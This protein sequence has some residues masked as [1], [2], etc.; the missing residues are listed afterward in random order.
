MSAVRRRSK[1]LVLLV[2]VVG[3][4]LVLSACAFL[5]EGSLSVSQSADI[6]AAH[7]H[8]VLCT[9][10]EEGHCTP[11]EINE[12]PEGSETVQYLIGIAV[13]KGAPAPAAFT[14]QPI[15]PGTHPINFTRDDQ[16]ASEIT[17][18]NAKLAEAELPPE[19]GEIKPWPPAGLEGVGYLSDPVEEEEGALG[20]WAVDAEFGLP[21][22]S[23]GSPFTGPF[24]A[25][26]TEGARQV[27]S[28]H[29]AGSPVHCWRFEGTFEEGEAFCGPT[30]EEAQVGTSDLKIAAPPTA[31]V[32]VGGKATPVF[33]LNLGSTASSLPSFNVTAT[34]T[35]P[36]ASVTVSAPNFAPPAVDPGTH[37]SGGSETVTVAVPKTAKPGVY[38]VTITAKTAQGGTATQVAKIEVTKPKLKLGKVKL[39]KSNGTVKLSIGVPGAG[40]LTVSGKKIVK[41]KRTAKGPKTIKVTIK[42]KGKAKKALGSTGK[43]KV[44]AKI[45]FKPSNGASV[46]KTKSITLKKKLG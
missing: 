27:S 26:I 32:F 15:S 29:P 11:N 34:S 46:T 45:V 1:Y 17:A 6:G 7:V 10:P 16:V 21:V 22:P 12:P 14:A 18:S 44:K 38:E 43:A 3:L 25:A 30:V 4:A 36:G 8:F 13:P 23:D 35:L 9:E 31:P 20:E 39:I 2:A 41:V 19:A 5:K 33:S 24:V 42:S 37:R 28:E 40:T